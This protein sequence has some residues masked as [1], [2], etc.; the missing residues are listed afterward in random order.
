LR[1]WLWA[2]DVGEAAL[3]KFELNQAVKERFDAEG[4]EFAYPHLMVVKKQ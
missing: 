3:L 1:A 4:I 2:A